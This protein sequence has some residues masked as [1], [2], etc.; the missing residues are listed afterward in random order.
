MVQITELT[1]GRLKLRCKEPKPVF[2]YSQ[3]SRHRR[4][5][6]QQLLGSEDLSQTFLIASSWERETIR[7]S[8]DC[9]TR[10]R[11]WKHQ[12]SNRSMPFVLHFQPVAQQPP[13]TREPIQTMPGS[14][15][16]KYCQASAE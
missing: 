16:Q 14:P 10:R 4:F 6:P 8:D 9:E 2:K 7:V 5:G 13:E 15:A 12:P 11:R 3:N 1:V